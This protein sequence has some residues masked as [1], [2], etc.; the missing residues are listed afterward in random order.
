MDARSTSEGAGIGD[1]GEASAVLLD[2]PL[3]QPYLEPG[4][5]ILWVGR[6]GRVRWFS[7]RR[8]G[9]RSL[10]LAL[11]FITSTIFVPGTI[12]AVRGGGFANIGLPQL[13]ICGFLLFTLI[14]AARVQ[15]NSVKELHRIVYAVS[16]QRAFTLVR[17]L[18]C[19]PL[20]WVSLATISGIYHWAR[21]DGSGCVVFGYDYVNPH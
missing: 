2:L 19:Q 18:Q 1:S 8:R 4:E 16:N 10:A 15:F 20:E 3:F 13:L 9:D 17:G 5:K 7:P 21:A 12:E 14:Q 11:L 6:P